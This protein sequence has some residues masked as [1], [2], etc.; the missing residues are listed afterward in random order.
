MP[1]EILIYGPSFLGAT[2]IAG[3]H[4]FVHRL[5]FLDRPQS[6]WLDVLAGV[7]LGY[8]F[9][10]ILPHLAGMQQKLLGA[11]E[12]GLLGFLEHHAYLVAMAG[13]LFYLAIA[14]SGE[15]ARARRPPE[16][17]A[18]FDRPIPVGFGAASMAAY[19]FLIGYMLAEQC[20]HAAGSGFGLALAMAAHFVGLDHF[21][22]HMYPRLY[23]AGL[24][25][26]LAAA[27]YG[28]WG[29]GVLGELSDETFAL[30]FAFL[31]GGITV[32]SAMFELPRV[33]SWRPYVGF[34][35][36]AVGFSA[37]VLTLEGLKP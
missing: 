16:D 22:R 11:T 26:G 31:A 5:R 28:G 34:C 30:L 20:T 25:Y 3:V 27:L 1:Q 17:F 36:G 32:I 14:V 37:L 35:A 13:F 6:I 15:R 9:V 24:R 19:A 4:L 10:D 8:V 12:A 21:Y 2:L 7:A 18:T 33:R 29:L 23:D